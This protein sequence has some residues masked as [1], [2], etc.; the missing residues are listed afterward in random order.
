MA[1]LKSP[2]S[3]RKIF[4]KWW[5]FLPAMLV[6]WGVCIYIYGLSQ[7]RTQPLIATWQKRWKMQIVWKFTWRSNKTNMKTPQLPSQRTEKK[8]SIAEW[9]YKDVCICEIES[10]NVYR[11]NNQIHAYQYQTF[12][13]Q[14]QC[15]YCLHIDCILHGIRHNKWQTKLFAPICF[16]LF[17]IGREGLW[18]KPLEKNRFNGV[19][20][21]WHIQKQ[22]WTLTVSKS[23]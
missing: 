17:A 8:Q 3:N 2:C 1:M 14:F 13:K 4:F 10:P 22:R 12:L 9:T 23:P 20:T 6:S 15:M 5:M 16:M 21:T 19:Q 11:I 7:H 18:Y